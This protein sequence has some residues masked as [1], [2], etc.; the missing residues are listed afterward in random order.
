MANP[1]DAWL[2]KLYTGAY[3][4]SVLQEPKINDF[5]GQEEG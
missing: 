1:N 3:Y 2:A 5:K 4:V